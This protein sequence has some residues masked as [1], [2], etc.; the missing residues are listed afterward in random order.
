MQ[1]WTPNCTGHV[2]KDEEGCAA[3][4][5]QNKQVNN[6]ST[7]HKGN[8]KLRNTL[9]SLVMLRCSVFSS[10]WMFTSLNS[11]SLLNLCLASSSTMPAAESISS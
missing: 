4:G 11:R 8:S 7:Q 1:G 2:K 10:K 3:T 5:L 6:A 9:F